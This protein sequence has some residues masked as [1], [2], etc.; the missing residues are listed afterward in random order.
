ML[1][2]WSHRPEPWHRRTGHREVAS[3][4]GP[5][6]GTPGWRSQW[7]RD[8]QGLG[9][10]GDLPR[11]VVGTAATPRTEG[12]SHRSDAEDRRLAAAGG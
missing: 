6:L 2:D 1:N 11:H 5:G 7:H 4:A 9:Q 12:G 8:A 10:L 3:T